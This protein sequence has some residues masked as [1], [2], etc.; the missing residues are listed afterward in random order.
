MWNGDEMM[1]VDRMPFGTSL[2][3]IVDPILKDETICKE[4]VE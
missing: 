3:H 1:E 2:F 4:E